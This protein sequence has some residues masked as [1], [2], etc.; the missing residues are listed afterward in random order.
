MSRTDP[1]AEPT[2]EPTDQTL[3]AYADGELPAG[4]AAALERRLAA[5]PDL[6]ARLRRF[7]ATRDLLRQSAVAQ[8]AALP[9][10][11]EAKV[12]AQ[13]A[14][15]QAEAGRVVPLAP[16]PEPS[17]RPAPAWP[18]ALAASVALAVGGLGGFLLGSGSGGDAPQV[19]GGLG[20]PGEL[21]AA[22]DR[23]AAGA[24]MALGD[25]TRLAP[26]ASFAGG[27]GAFCRE[28]RLTRP[29]GRARVEVACDDGTGWALRFAVAT[30]GAEG[31]AP[32]ASLEVLDLFL[33][34][35]GAGA[36]L[37][38]EAEAA[39]LAARIE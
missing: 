25:G 15:R 23:V 7:T 38:A 36:P 13:L 10:G 2:A 33:S 4:E 16:R 32:A 29:D 31:Y 3:M 8:P 30:G 17:R 37:T 34:Q 21:A 35:T 9:P 39:A 24:E 28:Y 14:A 11:L 22:L 5:E 12:R 6:A 26:V 19:A 20:L 27:D 1:P 18:A